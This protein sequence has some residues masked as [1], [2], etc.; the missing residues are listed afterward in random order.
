MGMAIRRSD[1]TLTSVLLNRLDPATYAI[2]IRKRACNEFA[3]VIMFI[4]N[5]GR[6]VAF[7]EH[8][9]IAFYEASNVGFRDLD[10]QVVFVE[11]CS[12]FRARIFQRFNLGF[13]RKG[14]SI[15]FDY[16]LMINVNCGEA[17]STKISL[18]S[19]RRQIF[20]LCLY[21]IDKL[22]L[23]FAL[24]DDN[25]AINY[26]NDLNCNED[27]NDYTIY[28]FYQDFTYGS[29]ARLNINDLRV[30]DGIFY[31]MY[32]PRFRVN[33]ALWWFSCAF[34]FFSAQGFCRS[35]TR[36]IFRALSVKLGCARAIS[37]NAGCVMKIIG[38]YLC[39]FTRCFLGF[40]IKEFLIC[41]IL[42]LLN[43]R[44]L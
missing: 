15:S 40:Y 28:L 38:D 18:R 9:T 36:F 21:G 41:L 29:N 16:V 31:Y 1:S 2:D 22:Y 4:F 19:Y 6:C 3:M 24:W 20:F 43:D 14:M 33:K 25:G 5:T 8:L 30:K 34:E 13:Q 27:F 32:F 35:A 39:F 37:A 10:F 11:E 12:P 42:W 44:R 23:I 7:R 26:T 17:L